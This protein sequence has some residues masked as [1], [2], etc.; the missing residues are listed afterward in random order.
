[1]ELFRALGV[2]AERPSPETG[3][4]ARALGLGP[5]PTAV[6]YTELFQLNLHPYAS[7]HLGDEGMLGGEARDRVAGF[8]RA[9]GLVPPSEPDHLAVLLGL[10]A[11]IGEAGAP[12]E[13]R[14][15]LLWEH[16]LPWL[17]AW[18]EKAMEIA[19][20]SYREWAE[21]LEAALLAQ[22]ERLPADGLVPLQLRESAPLADPRADGLDALVTSL[23]ASARS[24]MVLVRAD[25]V[26]AGREL[27]LGLRLGERRFVLRALLGQ[28]PSTSLRWLAAEAESWIGRH[29]RMAPVLAPVTDFWAT[30]AE[31][32]AA[33]FTELAKTTKKEV[34]GV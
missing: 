21:L 10:Y 12:E 26:R 27:G 9:L 28:D 19:P 17:P 18:L 7:V 22:A 13:V 30:R 6:E 1:M 16:L 4:I 33:L 31:R 24:G 3:A 25:L 34:V 11:T 29:R 32:T 15:A 14:R 8:W 20:P 2:L 23:L 5:V